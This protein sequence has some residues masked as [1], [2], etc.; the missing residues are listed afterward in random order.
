MI[1]KPYRRRKALCGVDVTIICNL[2]MGAAR[3]GRY[4]ALLR[5]AAVSEDASK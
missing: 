2:L 5:T 3:K 4:V 1:S